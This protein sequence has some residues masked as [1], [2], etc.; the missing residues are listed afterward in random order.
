MDSSRLPGKVMMPLY[1]GL[2]MLA[3]ILQKAHAMMEV[4][5]TVLLTTKRKEDDALCIL[6]NKLGDRFYRRNT[7]LEE[8]QKVWVYNAPDYILRICGDAPFIDIEL[9]N[10]LILE[11]YKHRGFSYYSYIHSSGKPA[12]LTSYGIFPEIFR[13]NN[14][15]PPKKITPEM[16]DHVTNMFYMQGKDCHYLPMP[17]SLEVIPFKC[18]VDTPED[19]ARIIKIAKHAPRN[20]RDLVMIMRRHP[21]WAGDCF[22]VGENYS[23]RKK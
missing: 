11:I 4:E 1:H 19:Y 3:V 9:T 21:E 23:W 7:V 15:Y 13:F 14:K 20:Y 2:P 8:Y 12:A 17:Q 18:T 10:R 22:S 6:A 16:E 5:H